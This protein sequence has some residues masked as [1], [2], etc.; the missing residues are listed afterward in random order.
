MARKSFRKFWFLCCL[1]LCMGL[2]I[3]L[4]DQVF[5][6]DNDQEDEFTLEEITVTA[7][8]REAQLQKIPMDISV[9]RPREMDR[10]GIYSVYDIKK[11]LP[12]IDTD[13]RADGTGSGVLVS[14]RGVGG[15]DTTLAYPTNETSTAVHIDGIQLTRVTSFDNMF[16]DLQRVEVLKGPQGTLY[17]RG[18]TAGTMNMMTQKPIIDGGLSGFLTLEAGNY[19]LYRSEAALNIPVNSKLAFRVAGRGFGRDGYTDSEEGKRESKGGRLS[20]TWEPTDKDTI[21]ATVDAQGSDTTGGYA[22][23]GTYWA[24]YGGV[25]IVPNPYGDTYPQTLGPTNVIALPYQTYW[26]KSMGDYLPGYVNTD[27][28]GAMVQWE[29]ELPFAYGVLLYGHREVEEETSFM[30]DMTGLSN[31]IS[32]PDLV[33]TYSSML[34]SIQDST[35]D[36]DSIEARLLS[37]KTLTAGDK[38]EWVVGAIYQDDDAAYNNLWDF[39]GGSW[40]TQVNTESIGLFAQAAYEILDNVNLTVGYRRAIDEK[41]YNG[42]YAMTEHA[43]P[44]NAAEWKENT[45]KVNLNWNIT[46]SVMTFVQY[47]RGYKT[48]DIQVG[49]DIHEPEFLDDYEFGFKTRFLDNRLQINTTGYYYDYKNYS[50]YVAY[51][52]CEMASDDP[53]NGTINPNTGEPYA[54]PDGICVDVASDPA[55]YDPT[56]PL[57]TYAGGPNGEIDAADYIENNAIFVSPGGA[58]QY[59]GNLNMIFLLTPNDTFT[60][61]GSYTHNEYK[62]YNQGEAILAIRPDADNIRLDPTQ[63]VDRSGEEFGGR[64]YRFNI[65]Y[66]HTRSIGLDLLSANF[67]AFYNGKDIDQ[68]MLRGTDNVYYMSGAPD[69]WTVDASITYNS[70]KWL[71]DGMNWSARIWCNNLFGSEE[72]NSLYYTDL[73]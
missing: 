23:N 68:I 20:M 10:L 58:K 50:S 70:S 25:S 12:D 47:S 67:T 65:G 18:S 35:G 39:T 54:S 59:G 36:F 41:V 33:I 64:P 44:Y 27:T 3:G 57:H 29:R 17:G 51:Q 72:L 4:S 61:N 6:Q 53:L 26:Y 71:P 14:I 16:Y 19:S 69:Y 55:D 52:V 49:G 11:I 8:K 48:G 73:S 13:S 40:V 66:T 56:N 31:V 1:S 24:T 32:P 30:W 43:V 9:V 60:F 63:R 42:T 62:N 45:Y 22:R 2:V 38:Y 46:D 5:A 28:W 21:T 7:E 15:G 37:K 34:F